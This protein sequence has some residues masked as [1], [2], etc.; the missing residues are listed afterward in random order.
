MAGSKVEADDGSMDEAKCTSCGVRLLEGEAESREGGA[1]CATCAAREVEPSAL[2][3]KPYPCNDCQESFT[4]G[5]GLAAHMVTA[6][7]KPGYNL[8]RRGRAGMTDWKSGSFKCTQCSRTFAHQP[9]LA[10]HIG[11]AH[12]TPASKRSR[13]RQ[14]RTGAAKAQPIFKCKRCGQICASLQ[15]LGG[16]ARRVHG[17][18]GAAAAQSGRRADCV[19]PLCVRPLPPAANV[20]FEHF[21]Q[22]GLEEG[23]ATRRATIAYGLLHV[24]S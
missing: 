3:A 17:R 4:S 21:V 2:S 16:H 8:G 13:R 6:H 9:A 5:R 23:Q 7:R 1:V 18:E 12:A 22:E 19:C 11:R 10:A 24:P 20:V 14:A 15:H